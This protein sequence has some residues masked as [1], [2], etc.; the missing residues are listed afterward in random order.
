MTR[1][2]EDIYFLGDPVDIPCFH[3]GNKSDRGGRWLGTGSEVV[4]CR[5]SECTRAVVHLLYDA[6]Y[7]VTEDVGA[8]SET[9]MNL[10]KQ[11]IIEKGGN[12]Y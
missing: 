2:S 10:T 7:D 11:A 1:L 4:V 9:L 5:D 6:I 8:T 12:S 3:C